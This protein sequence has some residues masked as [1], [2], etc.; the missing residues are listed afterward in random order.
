M[1]AKRFSPD[2]NEKVEKIDML[3]SFIKHGLSQ[4]EAVAESLIQM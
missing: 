4:E 3:Q 1:V 2:E